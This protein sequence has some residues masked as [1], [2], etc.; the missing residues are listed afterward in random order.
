MAGYQGRRLEWTSP[1]DAKIELWNRTAGPLHNGFSIN[2][3]PDPA[4][5][6]QHAA[7]IAFSVR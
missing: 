4:K 6:T 5:D 1:G 2:W 7:R 3:V